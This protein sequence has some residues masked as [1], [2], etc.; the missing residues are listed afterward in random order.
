MTLI[1]T[2]DAP[3][4]LLLP[5]NQLVPVHLVE[6]DDATGEPI[7][8]FAHLIRDVTL[9]TQYDGCCLHLEVLAKREPPPRPQPPPPPP[10]PPA[11]LLIKAPKK[12]SNPQGELEL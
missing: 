8:C 2:L 7:A 10:P 6:I 4:W 11:P 5:W 1:P 12:W 3:V 9:G